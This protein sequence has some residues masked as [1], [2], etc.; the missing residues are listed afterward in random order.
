MLALGHTKHAARARHAC[1]CRCCRN[2]GSCS[3]HPR[4]AEVLLLLLLCG[5]LLCGLLL[6]LGKLRRGVVWE[7]LLLLLGLLRAARCC[8][9]AWGLQAA[10][11]LHLG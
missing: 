1:R 8:P 7:R 10:R 6:L 5:L 2:R 11:L 9:R 3:C 4:V